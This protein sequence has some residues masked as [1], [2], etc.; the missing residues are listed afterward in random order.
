VSG[1]LASRRVRVALVALVQLVLV[2]AAVAGPLSARLTGRQ[3]LLRVAPLDPIDPFRGAY[4]ALTYPDL[5]P[6]SSADGTVPSTEVGSRS[7][8]TV[9]VSLV[10]DGAVW[11][12]RALSRRAPA[13]GPYLRCHDNSWQLRCGI[14]SWFLPEGKAAAAGRAVSAGNAV[15]VVRVDGRG[16]AALVEVRQK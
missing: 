9:F 11:R 3:Y 7:S 5:V 2:A 6:A 15:A 13:S 4:A 12:G 14:E 1:V 8:G 10:A 16:N